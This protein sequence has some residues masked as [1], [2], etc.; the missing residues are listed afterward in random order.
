MENKL[1]AAAETVKSL[2][3]ELG[4]TE[5][6]IKDGDFEM[7]LIKA[8]PVAAPAVAPVVA[9][10]AP[11]AVE[12]P[13]AEVPPAAETAERSALLRCKE[14]KSPLVGV[15][16]LAPAPGQPPFVSVGDTVS[17][18]DV[19]CIVEAMKMM[20]EITADCEGTVLDVCV[21]NEELVEY[22]QVLFKIG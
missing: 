11:S 19:L 8:A 10:A 4:L 6:R 15:T 7:E 18:G 22:G 13:P 20:N 2:F 12:A 16:Y 5:L 3:S 9:P 21:G 14:V 1:Q 17:R